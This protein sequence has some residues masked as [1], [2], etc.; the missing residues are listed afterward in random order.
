MRQRA[1][2]IVIGGN[3]EMFPQREIIN[4]KKQT[5]SECRN[6]NRLNNTEC[7]IINKRL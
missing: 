4:F 2:V 3:A 5:E 6:N 7:G 1:S